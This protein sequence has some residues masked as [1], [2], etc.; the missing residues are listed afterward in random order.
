MENEI[1]FDDFIYFI[2]RT[3]I[4][5]FVVLIIIHLF[6]SFCNTMSSYWITQWTNI[7]NNFSPIFGLTIYLSLTAFEGC[8]VIASNIIT[9]YLTNE[10]SSRNFQELVSNTIFLNLQFFD[11]TPIGRI[12]T[13][14]TRDLSVMDLSIPRNTIYL[15]REAI[16]L[17]TMYLIFIPLSWSLSIVLSIVLFG[18]YKL[19]VSLCFIYFPLNRSPYPKNRSWDENKITIKFLN[20]LFKITN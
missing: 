3:G 14:F 13:R 20:K 19:Q 7:E 1:K 9:F 11:V 6:S 12:V 16:Q 2:K 17:L 8:F 18:F 4:K 10:L 15:M 5:I